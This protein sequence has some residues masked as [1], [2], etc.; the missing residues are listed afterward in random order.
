MDRLK[1]NR[2]DVRKTPDGASK[3]PDKVRFFAFAAI[4][5]A[6]LA[7]AIL[8]PLL[9][10]RN[11]AGLTHPGAADPASSGSIVTRLGEHRCEPLPDGSEVCLNTNSA[12][13]YTF[14]RSTRNIEVVLGEASFVV[15][16]DRRPFDVLSGG[17]L[18]HDLSTRFDVYRKQDT[19]QMTVIQGAVKV[20]AP[21]TKET[22]QQFELGDPE[23]AWQGGLEVRGLQQVQFYNATDTLHVRPQLTEQSLSRLLAWQRGR[24]DLNDRTLGEALDE[25][26][27]YQPIG[28]FNYSDPL[29]RRIPV[30][31]NM[32][33]ANLDD[34]LAAIEHEFHVHHTTTGTD[35]NAVVTL[36]WQ[37]RSGNHPR[38]K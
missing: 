23:T 29:I 15:H 30:G 33:F 25:F 20:V 35:G 34:F 27:R 37:R 24:I 4:A 18:A 12:I 16:K 31:G 13:R 19:T 9:I 38:R 28:K 2:I 26:A 7:K 11:P 1:K 3:R 14:N 36:S 10:H 6:A 22:R 17:L 8:V 32:E 5:V 21:I